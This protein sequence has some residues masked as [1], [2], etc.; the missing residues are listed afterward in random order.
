MR[1]LLPERMLAAHERYK[2]SASLPNNNI[3]RLQGVP[4]FP[5]GAPG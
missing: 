5:H 3:A 2:Q 4:A 1:Q